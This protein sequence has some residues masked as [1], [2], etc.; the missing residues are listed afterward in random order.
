MKKLGVVLLLS[1]FSSSALAEASYEDAAQT[2]TH[3][4]GKDPEVSVSGSSNQ[5][6]ITGACTEVDISGASNQVTIE[7]T[8]KASITGSSNE[9]HITAAD[10]ISITG[11]NNQI[12]WKKGLKSKKPKVSRT[13]I[14]NRVKQVK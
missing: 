5:I 4:C 8:S 9:V 1:L 13:G 6:T 10:K 11:T 2:I 12:T 3:D 14:N 7:S